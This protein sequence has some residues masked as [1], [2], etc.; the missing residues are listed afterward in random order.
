[1]CGASNILPRINA[2]KRGSQKSAFISVD[3]RQ[4]SSLDKYSLYGYT[5][6]FCHPNLNNRGGTAMVRA[7]SLALLAGALAV[8]GCVP[9]DFL[10]KD[11]PV[12]GATA[13]PTSPF[14]TPGPAVGQLTSGGKTSQAAPET[15][16][17]VDKVGQQLVAANKSL[18]MQPLFLTV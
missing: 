1:M 7:L 2:D 16:I 3:P 5:A 8:A 14:T 12:S 9:S 15:A 17:I 13:V 11:P 10:Q 6:R 4:Y 18:G